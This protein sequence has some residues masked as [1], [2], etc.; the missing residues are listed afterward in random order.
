MHSIDT[1]TYTD[2]TQT[3]AEIFRVSPRL[4]CDSPRASATHWRCLILRW[5]SRL[6][7]FSSYPVQT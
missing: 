5:A 6:D 3:H 4:V 1:L 7:A 2:F